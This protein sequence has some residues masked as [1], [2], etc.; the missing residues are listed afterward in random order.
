M[1]KQAQ[2]TIV[3]VIE[4][5]LVFVLGILGNKIADLINVSPAVL[6]AGTCVII[7]LTTFVILYRLRLSPESLDGVRTGPIKRLMPRTMAT[8]FPLGMLVGL[9]GG[10]FLP[11][12]IDPVLDVESQGAVLGIASMLGSLI[13]GLPVAILLDNRLACALVFG[14]GI[15]IL[16]ADSAI[17][18]DSNKLLGY[19]YSFFG[20]VMIA[21]IFWMIPESYWQRARD[22]VMEKRL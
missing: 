21:G 10:G 4:T 7:I 11:L 19:L 15:G 8:I 16:M 14:Y 22:A 2:L 13:I 12:L 3:T 18:F 6:V 9:I 17:S 5:C 1:S 20:S